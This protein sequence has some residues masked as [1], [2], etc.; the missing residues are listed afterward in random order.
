MVQMISNETRKMAKKIVKNKHTIETTFSI[1]AVDAAPAQINQRDDESEK[2][3]N[4]HAQLF[5][6][7]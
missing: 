5:N 2:K 1:P 6:S 3:L 7:N 4:S